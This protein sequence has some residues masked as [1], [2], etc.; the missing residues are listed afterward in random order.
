MQQCRPGSIFFSQWLKTAVNDRRKDAFSLQSSAKRL[1]RLPGLL[2]ADVGIA[3]GGADILV[4]E[5]LLEF[6]VIVRSSLP[7]KG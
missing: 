5:E 3:H 1:C 4:P 7:S 2:V 6:A